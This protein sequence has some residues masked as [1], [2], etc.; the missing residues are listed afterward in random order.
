M[1][2][3]ADGEIHNRT[4]AESDVSLTVQ[5]GGCVPYQVEKSLDHLVSIQRNIRQTRIVITPSLDFF[6]QLRPDKANYILK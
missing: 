1:T 5:Y 3:I 6:P 2:N 4:T